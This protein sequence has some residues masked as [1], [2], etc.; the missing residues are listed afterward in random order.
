L[1]VDAFATTYWD[2]A[3]LVCRAAHLPARDFDDLLTQDAIDELLSRRGVR[4]PFL[5]MTRDGNVLPASRYTRGGGAG[6]E[7][8]DQ[9][10]D[11]KVLA[12]F[13]AGATFVLQ[14]LHRLWPPIRT[15]A[16]ALAAQLGHPVQVNAYVTPPM[17]QGFAAHYDVHDVFV[18]QFLGRK[19]WRIH[20]PVWSSPLRTQPWERRKADV[21]TRAAES[22]LLDTV[23]ERGDALYLPRG[24]VHAAAS[25][26]EISGHLTI[27]VHPVTRR[28]LVDEVIEQLAGEPA[29]RTALAAGRDL[30]DATALEDEIAATIT[31]M[32]AALDRLD[33]ATIARGI[34]R[35]LAS[36]TRPAPL[37][38]LAQLA[39]AAAL[40]PDTAV[41]LRPGLRVLV[42]DA[43]G[44]SVL[45]LPDDEQRFDGIDAETLRVATSGDAVAPAALPL[46]DIAQAMALVA[47]L[48]RAGIVVPA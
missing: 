8:A 13:A 18:L 44:G 39:A 6:A 43:E 21:A 38:P 20:E 37:G 24:Y 41:R 36:G 17:S 4:T 32:H 1:S 28:A 12:E 48:L 42:R 10:A 14:G 30:G 23:L 45:E 27:G 5:R 7:I 16:D 47:R 9:V 35:Q 40:T 31:A 46:P 3:P 15:F 2:R 25:L 22:P 33:P 11:D 26:G 34:R 19:R 29:L